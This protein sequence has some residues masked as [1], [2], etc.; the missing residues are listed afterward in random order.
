MQRGRATR[1][2]HAGGVEA[3]GPRDE[4]APGCESA[5]T[6]DVEVTDRERRAGRRLQGFLVRRCGG[7]SSVMREWQTFFFCE[8][9]PKR[10][11]RPAFRGCTNMRTWASNIVRITD[12][13]GGALGNGRPWI[14]AHYRA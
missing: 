13:G 1:V 12:C 7:Y 9:V 14:V 3:D 8:M 5:C 6:G 11:T 4:C 2:K 10:P